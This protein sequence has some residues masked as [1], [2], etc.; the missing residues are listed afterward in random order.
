M[1][2]K[3]GAQSIWVVDPPKSYSK[4]TYDQLEGKSEAD[5]KTELQANGEVFGNGN[6][7][8]MSDAHQLARKWSADV[9]V[10]LGNADAKTRAKVERWFLAAG[11]AAADVDA[12]IATLRDG[13]RKINATCNSNQ[14]IFSDRPHLRTSGDWDNAYASVNAGDVMPVI[15]IYQVFL[16]TGKRNRLGQIPKLWLCALTVIH[17][18]SHKLLDTKDHSYDYQ[19]LKPG[20]GNLAAGEAIKNADSWGYFAA[21]MM[22]AVSKGTLK[23]ILV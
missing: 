12:A 16:T 9:Q 3:K 11:A 17:E 5:L 7:K 13:F 8:M 1:V 18:L 21:D 6:R 19:G 2:Q 14:V 15:Y 20:G 10:K 4:W 22:G 23:Q